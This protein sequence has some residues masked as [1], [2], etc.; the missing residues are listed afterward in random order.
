MALNQL[1]Q[2]LRG[3]NERNRQAGM[4]EEQRDAADAARTQEIAQ[5]A[6]DRQSRMDLT[7]KGW[8]REDLK[9]K[10]SLA[11]QLKLAQMTEQKMAAQEAER[12]KREALQQEVELHKAQWTAN[13]QR[14]LE[15]MR[16]REDTARSDD[17][18]R[19]RERAA[20][21]AAGARPG[22]DPF[23]IQMKHLYNMRNGLKA[24]RDAEV[25]DLVKDGIDL[26]MLP[27]NMTEYQKQKVKRIGE[28]DSQ[29][30]QIQNAIN[31]QFG[32]KYEF[33]PFDM[34]S[35]QLAPP[36]GRGGGAGGATAEDIVQGKR[37][38]TKQ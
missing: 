32:N 23:E 33:E 37:P 29:T 28:I 6:M 16:Q 38:F 26:Q 2:T 1:L 17:A 30:T 3:F 34:G 18:N 15:E 19:S 22:N 20:R 31:A 12:N 4:Y 8:E 27:A 5:H 21:I 25:K 9:E 35:G 10:R 24:Q 36:G 11:M 7:K 14:T 13:Q